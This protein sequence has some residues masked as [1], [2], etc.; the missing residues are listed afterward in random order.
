MYWYIFKLQCIMDVKLI[1][2]KICTIIEDEQP[3]P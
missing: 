1:G 2:S 3:K